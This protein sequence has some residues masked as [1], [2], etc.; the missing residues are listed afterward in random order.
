MPV[1]KGQWIYDGKLFSERM[2]PVRLACSRE[3][4]EKVID[5]TIKYYEQIA[6]MAYKISEEVIIKHGE[7]K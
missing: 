6:V 2:I 7:G 3:Q 4:I 5:F 1:A